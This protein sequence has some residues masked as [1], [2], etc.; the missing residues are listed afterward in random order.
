MFRHLV[1]LA[2]NRKRSNLL[3]MLE[4]LLAFFVVFSVTTTGLWLYAQYTEPLG[5]FLL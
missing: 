2:W 5:F 3:L 4:I 1:R